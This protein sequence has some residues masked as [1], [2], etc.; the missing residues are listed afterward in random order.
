MKIS[1]WW[2][3]SIIYMGIIF[4]LSSIPGDNT[5]SLP[6]PFFDKIAHLIE[7]TG[8]GWLLGN[9]FNGSFLAAVLTGSLY[10]LSDEIHQ[11]FVPGR[12]CD[13]KDL[14]CDITGCILGQFI[15][16]PVWLKKKRAS[17]DEEL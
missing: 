2:L 7:Y 4:G 16:L 15:R 8:F 13:F 5:P 17:K 9:A 12:E 14:L 11:L 3:F 10:G 6:F 1:R